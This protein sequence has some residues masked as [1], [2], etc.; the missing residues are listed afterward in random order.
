M[1]PETSLPMWFPLAKYPAPLIAPHHSHRMTAPQTK[2]NDRGT[3][4]LRKTYVA[5]TCFCV[6]TVGKAAC[7]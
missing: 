6:S 7:P 1:D 5:T 2:K 3:N 4:S